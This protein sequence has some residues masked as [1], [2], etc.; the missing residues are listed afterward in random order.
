MPRTFQQQPHKDETAVQ[1]RYCPGDMAVCMHVHV[2]TS[3][4]SSFTLRG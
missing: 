4:V 3:F 1:D 2:L